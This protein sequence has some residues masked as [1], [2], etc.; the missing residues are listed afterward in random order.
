MKCPAFYLIPKELTWMKTDELLKIITKSCMEYLVTLGSFFHT[1]FLSNELN[2]KE[3]KKKHSRKEV[4][5]KDPMCAQTNIRVLLT[6]FRHTKTYVS[7]TPEIM[8]IMWERFISTGH[9]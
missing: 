8:V 1:S 4:S 3:K 6:C 2:T 5:E 7:I 9:L